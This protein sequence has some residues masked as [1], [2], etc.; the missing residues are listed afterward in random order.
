MNIKEYEIFCP[1]NMDISGG[2]SQ[3]ASYVIMEKA[4]VR[5]VA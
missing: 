2:G 4:K 5:E 3:Y 1:G